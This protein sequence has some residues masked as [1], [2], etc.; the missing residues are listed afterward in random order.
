MTKHIWTVIC[1]ES[2]IEAD[3]NNISVIDAYESLQFDIKVDEKEFDKTKPVVG[4]FNFE[5]LSL[6]Y[7]DK[8]GAEEILEVF[9]VLL[10]PKGNQ[11]IE[12]P[13]KLV[14]QEQHNRMRNR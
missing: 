7:R 6:F 5:V 10:D 13:S 12:F 14:F 1:R 2:K 11:L 3:T 9:V 4:P 8:K